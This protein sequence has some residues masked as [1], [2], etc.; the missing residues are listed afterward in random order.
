MTG[1]Q[2]ILTD[3]SYRGQ[4]VVM[5]QPHIGNYGISASVAE[6]VHP[7]VEGFVARQ[8]TAKASSH[9]SEEELLSYLGRNEIPH[10]MSSIRERSYAG[11]ANRVRCA[12]S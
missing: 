8:F 2:E 6:S 3:P 10:W 12:V 11:C 1:Y 4:I 9:G 7:W 5:T